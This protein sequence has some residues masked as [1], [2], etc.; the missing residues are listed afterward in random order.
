VTD[1]RV[2]AR[3]TALGGLL[4][5]LAMALS[6]TSAAAWGAGGGGG[7]GGG[8]HPIKGGAHGYKGR[9]KWGGKTVTITFDKPP[10]EKGDREWTRGPNDPK[11]SG[12][13]DMSKVKYSIDQT[14]GGYGITVKGGTNSVGLTVDGQGNP[15]DTAGNQMYGPAGTPGQP[16]AAVP[17]TFSQ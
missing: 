11:D 4:S 14:P 9:F 17:I 12:F 8:G 16:S 10:S 6:Y 2:C 1:I 7:G 5:T 15:L 3:R 13:P